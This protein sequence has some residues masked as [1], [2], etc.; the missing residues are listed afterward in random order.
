MVI[1]TVLPDSFAVV[2]AT[3]VKVVVLSSLLF[4][5]PPKLIETTDAPTAGTP[6]ERARLRSLPVEL[7][8]SISTMLAPGASAWT[9]STSPAV[10]P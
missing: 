4:S 10:S 3:F 1:V 6:I 5:S 7:V 9:H 2:I 8:S